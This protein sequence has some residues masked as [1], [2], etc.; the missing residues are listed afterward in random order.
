MA[1][2]TPGSGA[3]RF[4]KGH[5]SSIFSPSA[6]SGVTDGS[7]LEAT[8]EMQTQV[9]SFASSAAAGQATIVITDPSVIKPCS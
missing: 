4:T 9:A 5:H 8:V 3:V 7:E 1:T 6:I 2:T